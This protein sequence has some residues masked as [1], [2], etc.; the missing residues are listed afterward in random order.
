MK[1]I[2]KVVSF[3][4]LKIFRVTA[5]FSNEKIN[6]IKNN[7]VIVCANH[8]SFLDGVIIALLSP[9]PLVF[10]VDTEFSV[11]SKASKALFSCLSILGFGVVVP[12]DMNN[13]FGIRHLAKSL[14]SGKSVMIFPEGKISQDGLPLPHK[15]GVAWLVKMT[16][17]PVVNIRIS[18]AEKSRFFG[19]TGTE[20]W[21]KIDVFF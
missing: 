1:I 20:I 9:I 19:K 7:T 2:R 12:V 10:G 16:G 11:K 8:V 5:V 14:Q 13:P 4:L 15:P 21:P 6:I 3:F 17:A 18:G